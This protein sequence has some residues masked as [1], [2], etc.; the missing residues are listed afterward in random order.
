VI[1]SLERAVVAVVNWVKSSPLLEE[2]HR[3]YV[4]LERG[5]THDVKSTPLVDAP[6][7]AKIEFANGLLGRE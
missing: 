3:E 1:L 5:P 4:D 7:D 6:Y 2:L